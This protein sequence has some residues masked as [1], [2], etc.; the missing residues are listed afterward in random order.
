MTIETKFAFGQE[1]FITQLNRTGRVLEI[2]CNEWG[3]QYRIR[4][5]D[6]ASPQTITF[7]EN[8]LDACKPVPVQLFQ[9]IKP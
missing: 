9:G 5:F 7:F 3:Q 2:Y 1:V 6:N 8:E 4:Y